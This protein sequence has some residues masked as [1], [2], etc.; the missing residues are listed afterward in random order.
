[1]GGRKNYNF[2]KYCTAHVEQHNQLNA[3][4]KFRVQDMSKDMKIHYFIEGIKDESFNSIKTTILADHSKFPNFA[5]VMGLYSNFKCLQMS[6]VVPQACTVSALT[7]GHGGGGQGRGRSG[8]GRGRGGNS[9]ASRLVPQEEVDR[10]TDI[11]AKH[12]P[13]KVYNNFT[14]A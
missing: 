6:D 5:S 14:P 2:D 11:E 7:Q 9:C 8:R 4:L 12:Y 10:L 1:M 13:T 3:L